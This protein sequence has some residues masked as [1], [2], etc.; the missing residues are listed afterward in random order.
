MNIG[1]GK[2][3]HAQGGID[4]EADLIACQARFEAATKTS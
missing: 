2:A 1:V 4:T 3:T